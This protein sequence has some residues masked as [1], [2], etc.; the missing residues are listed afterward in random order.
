M[1]HL[2]FLYFPATT[3]SRPRDPPLCQWFRGGHGIAVPPRM[4][5]Q[6]VSTEGTTEPCRSPLPAPRPRPQPRGL[7]GADSPACTQPGALGQPCPLFTSIRYVR[8]CR[9]G[10]IQALVSPAGD[11]SPCTVTPG[12]PVAPHLWPGP[13][14]PAVRAHAVR[15][16]LPGPGPHIAPPRRLP[17]WL[18]TANPSSLP[19][20]GRLGTGRATLVASWALSCCSSAAARSLTRSNA[21]RAMRRLRA[22]R[23]GDGT[24]VSTGD[25]GGRWLR[26]PVTRLQARSCRR[27]SVTPGAQEVVRGSWPRGSGFRAHLGVILPAASPRHLQRESSRA[28][29]TPP[30]PSH[31]CS[32]PLGRREARLAVGLAGAGGVAGGAVRGGGS[33]RCLLGGKEHSLHYPREPARGRRADT[34]G[35]DRK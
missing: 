16:P 35:M 9:S 19:G 29:S 5:T 15:L 6:G 18:A 23:P 21:H 1:T 7:R 31:A 32:A 30:R 22:A 12:V 10:C 26:G 20:P 4:S 27:P 3:Q 28:G 34:T 8:T 33:C 14:L 17:L 24:S 25:A 2:T 11:T 13:D